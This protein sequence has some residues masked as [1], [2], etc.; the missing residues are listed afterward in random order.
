MENL[1]QSLTFDAQNKK[2][3]FYRAKAYRHIQE[4]D[5]AKQDL[6]QLNPKDRAVAEELAELEKAINNHASEERDMFR[7]MVNMNINNS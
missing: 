3:Y 5:L 2:A 1:L 6:N 4:F 7:K